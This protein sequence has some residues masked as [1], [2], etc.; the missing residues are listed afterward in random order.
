MFPSHFSEIC[1]FL[2][3]SDEQNSERNTAVPKEVIS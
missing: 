3:M 2:V 1:P